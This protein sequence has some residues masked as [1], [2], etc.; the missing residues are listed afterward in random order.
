MRN[1]FPARIDALLLPLK[2]R[3]MALQPRERLIIV[4]GS[5]LV[6]LIALYTLGIAPLNKAVSERNARVLQKQQD[7]LWMQSIAAPL[8]ALQRAQPAQASAGESLVV[9]IANSASSG[10]IAGA[11]TG[12]TPDGGNGVRV[13]FEGVQFDAL[14]VWLGALQRD[15]GIQVKTAEINRI[16]QPG[17]V[18]ASLALS[19]GG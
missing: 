3:F 9:V 8:S 10:N 17:Q 12:Q 11:L 15:Y 13:R 2:E 18:N 1:D 14:V 19:R 6:L 5:I 7:L 16:A 4:V